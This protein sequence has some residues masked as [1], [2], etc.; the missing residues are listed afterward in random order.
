MPWYPH[1]IR[2]EITKH[3][4]PL[5]VVNRENLHVAVSEALSL[6]GFFSTAAVCSHFY[7][8]KDG[9]V[10]QYVDTAV[11]AAADLQGNDATISIETQGGVA[12]AQSEPW[13]PAQ[14]T[15]LQ[16]LTDWICDTH[17]IP[18]RLAVDSRPGDSSRGI[19]WHRLGVDPWRVAGGMK[20]SNSRGKI[21]PGDAKIAQIP[22]VLRPV[23]VVSS[24]AP[25]VIPVGNGGAVKSWLTVGDNGAPVTA[26]Q[27]LLRVAGYGI[28][29]DGIFGNATQNAVRDYQASR[30]LVIDGIAGVETLAALRAGTPPVHVLTPGV[31]SR[32]STGSPVAAVQTKLRTM[33]PAY[34]R[35]VLSDGIFGP[36][37]EA[38]VKE[39]QRRSGLVTDGVVGPRTLKALGL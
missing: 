34:A 19:S 17:G 4:T 31:L 21:C 37:T 18:R 1:A 30:G 6:F 16:A 10:E 8:R 2:K 39:F 28:A 36:A 12:D 22:S 13:T 7:V 32:G 25:I 15:A 38:A 33:Y 29:A 35:K 24:P 3:R 11:R 5:T 27:E 9:T 26:L 14:I 23:Q 20:Y